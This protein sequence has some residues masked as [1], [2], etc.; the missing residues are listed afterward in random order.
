MLLYFR[1]V[2]RVF[3]FSRGSASSSQKLS[4]K[5]PISAN[6]YLVLVAT[7]TEFILENS[8]SLGAAHELKWITVP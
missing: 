6:C 7:S 8:A 3:I 5:E 1:V 4:S 2:F